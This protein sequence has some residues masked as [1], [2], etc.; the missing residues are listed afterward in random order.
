MSAAGPL[1]AENARALEAA[2]ESACATIA[3][4]W[5]MDRLIAV[6]PY[7]G[8]LER[9][10]ERADHTLARLADSRLWMSRSYYLD[11]WQRGEI[12]AHHLRRALRETQ[13]PVDEATAVNALRRAAPRPEWAPLP[14]PSE[15]LDAARKAN[16]PAWRD[17]ITQ[18][19]SQFC[20]THFDADQ[21][22]WHP[23]REASLYTGWLQSMRN[24]HSIALLM[25]A[26]E[27]RRRARE[28]PTTARD[29][30]RWALDRLGVETT[31]AAELLRAVLLR[32][33][34]WA[35][36]C[37]WLRWDARLRGTDDDTLVELLAIR[38]AWECL[39]DD[40][41]GANDSTW[42]R[43]YAAWQRAGSAETEPARPVRACWQ[44]ALELAYQQPLAGALAARPRTPKQGRLCRRY[45]AS[46]CVPK[47]S[48]APS[49]PPHPTLRHWGLPVFSACRLSTPHSA[50]MP[51][52]RNCRGCWHHRSR[53][54]KAAAAPSATARS[55]AS[56]S[57]D[58]PTGRSGCGSSGCPPRRSPGSS[59]SGWAI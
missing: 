49:R 11:A 27:V 19:V 57:A 20:A 7:W 43:R 16:A 22:D 17:V 9:S 40:G 37:A 50:P 12:E 42:A 29:A 59:R 26:P 5:P 15:V 32:I 36:W 14:L 10:F 39:V 1:A 45:S 52:S 23:E 55:P 31:A 18:Q 48:A 51:R 25:D 47:Y 46:T 4:N 41:A 3:P 54:P 8:W 44:R 34:G 33:N 38:L 24:D 56:A 28:L 2:I 53:S 13:A 35:A 30:I 58:S 6:N 21:A